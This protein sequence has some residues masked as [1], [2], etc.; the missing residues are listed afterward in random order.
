LYQKVSGVSCACAVNTFVTFLI[1]RCCRYPCNSTS[2]FCSKRA[3]LAFT[4]LQKILSLLYNKVHRNIPPQDCWHGHEVFYVDGT[5]VTLDDTAANQA[6][7]PQPESQ[8]KGLGFPMIRVVL[9]FSMLT[10][11]I[12][13]ARF[14][15]YQG[16]GTGELSLLRSL[17]DSFKSGDILV[18]DR[19]YCTYM[20]IA[21]M[22]RH[23]IF[24]CT[25]CNESR[26]TP[27]PS[28]GGVRGGL[29]QVSEK[30]YSFVGRCP[31]L[32]IQGFQP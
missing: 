13:T 14:A 8:K 16:K 15:P 17:L 25:R 10:A 28:E 4:A 18:A 6:A 26:I 24:I 19:L 11:M 3:K 30:V 20:M 2:N 23:G 7:F 12:K 32:L 31:T 29:I 22:L 21:L 1:N 9:V 5:E 27:N